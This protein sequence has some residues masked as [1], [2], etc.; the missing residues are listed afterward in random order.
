M[1][2]PQGGLTMFAYLVMFAPLGV[3]FYLSAR[4]HAMS[5]TAAQAWFWGFAA[6]MG[7]SMWSVFAVFTGESIART[8]FITAG[9]FGGL[10]LYGYTT[11]R[12]LSGLRSFF[13]MGMI[14]LL[15]ASI[16]NIFMESSPLQF[17]ISLIGVGL[18]AGLTAYDTQRLKVMYYQL[19]GYGVEV[20]KAAIMG[21][22]NL[23]L[24]FINMFQFLL[25]FLGDRR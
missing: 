15:I 16:V 19:A 9:A 2:S 8:F 18:F 24:D 11:K 23:Y 1:I 13:V 14:G 20:G 21:A 5:E 7:L 3:V 22:L 6:V 12:D 17:A 10:S 4:L 25:H